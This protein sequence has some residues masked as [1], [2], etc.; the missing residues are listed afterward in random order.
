MKYLIRIIAIIPSATATISSIVA[1]IVALDY[2]IA[3]FY[4][5]GLFSAAAVCL[6]NYESTVRSLINIIKVICD[7]TICYDE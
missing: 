4:A 2:P 5:L 1:L 6:K 7:K 3:V